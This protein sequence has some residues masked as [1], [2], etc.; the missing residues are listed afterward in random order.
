[1]PRAPMMGVSG[2]DPD[3]GVVIVRV[4]ENRQLVGVFVGKT[5]NEIMDFVDTAVDPD[6]C[7][8]CVL[9]S[10]AVTW[11][12]DVAPIPL[13]D[14]YFDLEEEPLQYDGMFTSEATD[15]D[16]A[17]ARWWPLMS[18]SKVYFAR[19]GQRVKIGKAKNVQARLATLQTGCPDKIELIMTIPGDHALER[20]LHHQFSHLREHGEWFRHEGELAAFLTRGR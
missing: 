17:V 5:E 10:L 7:E 1:M 8:Y 13:P 14:D 4:I 15:D 6:C 9:D 16:L 3:Y 2:I 12:Q 19:A 18:A 20:E 11:P